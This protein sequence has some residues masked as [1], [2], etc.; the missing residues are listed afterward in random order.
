MTVLSSWLGGTLTNFRTIR[1]RLARIEVLVKLFET[2]QT[3]AYSK[4]MKST[5]K[6]IPTPLSLAGICTSERPSSR[7]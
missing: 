5:L 2:G 7:T 6:P 1:S 4:K 3:E